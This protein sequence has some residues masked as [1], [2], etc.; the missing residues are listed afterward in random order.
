MVDFVHDAIEKGK[1]EGKPTLIDFT[2]PWCTACTTQD[3]IIESV[4]RVL[5][6]AI[7]VKIDVEE[8]SEVAEGYDILSLPAMLLFDPKGRLA[9]RS[10]GKVVQAPDIMRI[11]ES[12]RSN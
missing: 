4:E 11:V 12:T 6:D 2:A 7:I 9:W 5:K 10:A 8:H 1:K 3:G